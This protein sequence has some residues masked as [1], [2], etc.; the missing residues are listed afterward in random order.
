VREEG[1]VGGEQPAEEEDHQ[2]EEGGVDPE[3]DPGEDAQAAALGV[4]ARGTQVDSHP[5]RPVRPGAGAPRR[6]RGEGGHHVA[7][8]IVRSVR[9]RHAGVRLLQWG[10]QSAVR[11]AAAAREGAAVGG[12][13]GHSAGGRCEL[14]QVG[15]GAPAAGQL[16]GDALGQER[17]LGAALL[18]QQRHPFAVG[19]EGEDRQHHEEEEGDRQEDRDLAPQADASPP[20]GGPGGH[21][22]SGARTARPG[23]NAKSR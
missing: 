22:G 5:A 11:E 8:G 7:E 20:G 17:R 23:P 15:F 19:E 13:H 14:A 2:D 9:S 18:D 3:D 6:D 1:V 12:Q 4:Q 16:G 21:G 10:E